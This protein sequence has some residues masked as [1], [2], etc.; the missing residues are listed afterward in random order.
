MRRFVYY[1]AASAGAQL[2]LDLYPATVAYSVRKLRTAYTGA[3]MR[4][5]RSSDNAEQDI[6]FS[7]NDLDTA[8]L[9]SFVG[10]GNGFITKVYNQGSG[11]SVNDFQQTNAG[12]QPLII[13]S[14]SLITINSKAVIDFY[15]SSVAKPPMSIVTANR[16]IKTGFGVFK[17][18]AQN[19]VN[20]F[21]ASSG[22]SN[23][24]FVNGSFSGING[25]GAFDGTNTRS[26]T[27]KDLNRQ[28]GYWNTRSGNLYA[29][30]NGAAETNTGTFNDS[31]FLQ[32]DSLCGR[33]GNAALFFQGK[34]QE[35]I[36]FTTD[37]SANKAA[38][39]SNINNYY[40][41]Y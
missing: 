7:G 10:A 18:D 36:G 8:A 3:C 11:G 14:G 32:L 29:A 6:G 34:F 24:T 16:I 30:K 22:L 4:V 20:Y 23:G 1:N 21:I 27:G 25:I 26:I 15:P 28:L 17:V 37:E 12:S 31:S 39:E 38:I 40:G 19:T 13:S 2:L 41:I 35:Y 33:A 5:R 9:L